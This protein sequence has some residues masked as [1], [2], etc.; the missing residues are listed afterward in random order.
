[1]MNKEAISMLIYLQCMQDCIINDKTEYR[2]T[3]KKIYND[4]KFRVD[5]L[6]KDMEGALG[7]DGIELIDIVREKH[8]SIN[9]EFLNQLELIISK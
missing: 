9:S 4:L 1:M 5:K 3:S 8:N 2:H 6:C 7:E